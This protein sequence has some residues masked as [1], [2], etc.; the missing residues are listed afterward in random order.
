MRTLVMK[1]MGAV[2]AFGAVLS[3]SP[4]QAGDIGISIGINGEVAPG[5]YGRVNIGNQRPLLVYGE[6]LL[7]QRS[8]RIYDPWYLHVPPGHLRHWDR[9]CS[10]YG[11]CARPVYFVKS[12]D[13]YNDWDDR[14]IERRYIYTP[15]RVYRGGGG[16][17]HFYD[18]GERHAYRDGYRDGRR[19]ER[20]DDRWDDRRGD[21]YDRHDRHDHGDRGRGRGRDD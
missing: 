10:R 14:Y 9:H 15:Q 3:V 6:P 21:R 5:V 12:H 7:I 18:R 1:W 17:D 4:A 8:S 19:E 11:A 13:Y 20:R 2:L 16:Y